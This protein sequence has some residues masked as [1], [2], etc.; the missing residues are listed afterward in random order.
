MCLKLHKVYGEAGGISR[1]LNATTLNGFS[2][3]LFS[4]V[5]LI[6]QIIYLSG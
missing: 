5:S 4:T 2:S 1:F 6:Y 3:V